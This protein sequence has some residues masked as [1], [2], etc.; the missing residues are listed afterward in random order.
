MQ[1]S[2]WLDKY[3]VFRRATLLWAVW[4]ITITVMTYLERGVGTVSMADA[5]IITGVIG[6]LAVVVGFQTKEEVKDHYDS[7]Y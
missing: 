2:S 5:T 4:L 3:K 6:I 7:R 1:S